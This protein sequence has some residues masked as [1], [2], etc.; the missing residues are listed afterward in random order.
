VTAVGKQ[1]KQSIKFAVATRVA[2]TAAKSNP[3]AALLIG[4]VSMFLALLLVMALIAVIAIDQA[5]QAAQCNNDVSSVNVADMS[6]LN[7]SPKQKRVA[8]QIW[9][10]IQSQMA[11]GKFPQSML[12]R[13]TVITYEASLT[14]SGLTNPR[15]GDRDSGGTFQMRPSA[16]WGTRAQVTNVTYATNKFLS[17]MLTVSDWQTKPYGDVAADVERPAQQY[18]YRYA[19][20][21]SEAESIY[22]QL[23]GNNSVQTVADVSP[24]GTCA[25][26]D[27][28]DS[29]TSAAI[30]AALNA[31]GNDYAGNTDGA[32]LVS[33]F[34]HQAGLKL[35]SSLHDL[36]NFNGQPD[37][38][39]TTQWIP[40]SDITSGREP[41]KPGDILFWS[42]SSPPSRS[43]VSK[44]GLYVGT[45]MGDSMPIATYNV[46]GSTHTPATGPQSGPERIQRAAALIESHH[47]AVVGMQEL[48]ANQR[49]QLV[50]SL[51]NGYG[52]YPTRPQYGLHQKGINSVN[53]IIWDKSQV[54]FVNGSSL[55]MPYYFNR[56]PMHIPLVKMLDMKSGQPFFVA[57]TH[58]PAMT[59]FA[60]LRYLDALQ[61]ASDANNITASGT[62]MFF[63]GDFNSAYSEHARVN[64]VWQHQRRY[65]TWCVMTRSGR[66]LDGYDAAQ[67]PVR[68]G[69]CPE[70][71]TR[72][73]GGPVDH[74]YVSNNIHVSDYHYIASR[75]VTASDHGVVYIDAKL[76]GSVTTKQQ[77]HFGKL[78][79]YVGVGK[80]GK[81]ALQ[82]VKSAHLAGALRLKLSPIVQ[83][84][85]QTGG[86]WQ[87][88]IR[89]QAP[90]TCTYGYGTCHGSE[91]HD[92]VDLG[93]PVGTAVYAAHSGRVY[94][95]EYGPASGNQIIIANN[96]VPG[97]GLGTKYEHLSRF[98]PGIQPG[99]VVSVGQLIGYSGDTGNVTGPH[100][101][102]SVC[103]NTIQCVYGSGVG[104]SATTDPIPFMRAHGVKL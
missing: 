17:V 99:A 86:P 66:M 47:F 89:V 11:Q 93:V 72:E 61:H 9:A 37:L 85:F 39:L 80:N 49:A 18:R 58:D 90:I 50:R 48:Q 98:A 28:T 19:T 59:P 25:G 4:V 75:Q 62:P 41:L 88:P 68:T 96:G 95:A 69:E 15:G 1:N 20:H 21:E 42:D 101:H 6:N 13:V 77:P 53:S 45:D 38:G 22:R 7:L 33:S 2:V 79:A 54:S 32:S 30:Q 102:F 76:P 63:T 12:E 74:V 67:N 82:S 104:T 70:Q 35:P 43:N 65:M 81:I 91:A 83:A 71:T 40:A 26:A 5:K 14:E 24:D 23:S 3:A 103:T 78:G 100:L 56:R 46:R 8:G 52:I 97:K 57:N 16:G 51:G 55:P 64:P 44:A 87:D 36:A 29:V 84:S 31:V 73:K 27:P 10:V 60:K 94:K 92:G 34:Y